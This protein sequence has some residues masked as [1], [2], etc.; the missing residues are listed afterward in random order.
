MVAEYGGVANIVASPF[1]TR[2]IYSTSLQWERAYKTTRCCASFV[3]IGAG[4]TAI[5]CIT[6]YGYPRS[7]AAGME[8]EIRNRN[9]QLSQDILAILSDFLHIPVI[10]AGDF[11]VDLADLPPIT[12]ALGT[13]LLHDLG[14]S[15]TADEPVHT[16]HHGK[17][18]TT[19]I[20]LSLIHISEP[21]RPY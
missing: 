7:S 18:S 4:R 8:S 10:I 12:A 16:Y 15:F 3:P 1:A 6:V 20:D 14:A 21:T 13:G 19:R 11:N 17:I 5:L 2:P 9:V